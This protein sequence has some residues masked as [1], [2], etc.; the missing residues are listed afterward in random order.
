PQG[1]QG[2]QGSI[3]LTGAEG[4]QGPPGPTGA[5]GPAGPSLASGWEQI[6]STPSPDNES[7]KSVTATCTP[8]KRVV[9][10]GFITS[11][12]NTPG[13]IAITGSYPDGNSAWTVTGTLTAR[14]GG[15]HSYS[16]TAY[17]ICITYP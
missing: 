10:G 12:A 16:L 4:P 6:L 7:P 15:D 1:P 8:G 17:A 3:G 9:S 11:A 13:R 5:T 2:P 14:N